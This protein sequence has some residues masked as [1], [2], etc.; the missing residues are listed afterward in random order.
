MHPPLT[1]PHARLERVT[2]T[3]LTIADPELLALCRA[4]LVQM[5]T[6]ASA[7]VE[8]A[9]LVAWNAGNDEALS[10]R[11]RHALAW[12]EQ[13]A[14]DVSGVSDDDNAG[15][16]SHLGGPAFFNFVQAIN[17]AEAHIRVC[18]FLGLQADAR[19]PRSATDA[20]QSAVANWD[21]PIVAGAADV[22]A[23]RLA[24]TNS[25]FIATFREFSRAAHQLR[26][27]D[28]RASELVRLRNAQF[29]GCRYCMSFRRQ[30][31]PG[32][33]DLADAVARYETS[34]LSES[35]KAILR[36]VDGFLTRP[37]EIDAGTWQHADRLLEPEAIPEIA[38][39]LASWMQDKSRIALRYDGAFDPTMLSGFTYDDEGRWVL[40]TA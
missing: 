3:A 38:Y 32:S 23:Y 5:L 25:E 36:L 34:H 31:E 39:K 15:L 13:F 6:A 20:S 27:L 18:A 1:E 28:D 7:A 21:R 17:M 9:D 37:A 4:R 29:Q 10:A 24:V 12:V 19:P 40:A 2:A 26:V 35:D 30:V 11:H 8:S 16:T 33:G 22:E 14:T